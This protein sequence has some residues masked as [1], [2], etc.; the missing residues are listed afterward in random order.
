MSPWL[1]QAAIDG[2]GPASWA[3]RIPF[4]VAIPMGIIGWYIRRAISDTPNFEKL[5]EKADC[6]A[7]R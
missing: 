7:T 4:L 6:R 5:K 3:W 1:N 2:G